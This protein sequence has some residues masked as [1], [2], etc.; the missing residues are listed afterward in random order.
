M[1]KLKTFAQTNRGHQLDF[2][3]HS[4]RL[5]FSLSDN[6]SNL[7]YIQIY[8]MQYCAQRYSDEI[9]RMQND[10]TTDSN[11]FTI[12]SGD[13]LESVHNKVDMIKDMYS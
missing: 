3:L 7:T 8:F 2:L 5:H 11:A 1:Q 13:S 9:K 10:T 6:I 4:D 12:N